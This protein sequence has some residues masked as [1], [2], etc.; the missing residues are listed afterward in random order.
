MRPLVQA[1]VDGGDPPRHAIAAPGEKEIDVGVL[2]ERV[3]RR[4]QPGAFRK[5]QR[6]HPMGIRGV[7]R[8]GVVDEAA[9]VAS[10]ADRADLDHRTIRLNSVMRR[11]RRNLTSR[12]NH[13]W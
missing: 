13:E 4:I 3:L 5:S 11:S 9:E 8:V 7:A 1:V 10:A 6:R 12:A 2:E